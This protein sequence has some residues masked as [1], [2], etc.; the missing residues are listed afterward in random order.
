MMGKSD[1]PKVLRRGVAGLVILLLLLL[2]LGALVGVTAGKE[3]ALPC[4][5]TEQNNTWPCCKWTCGA[6]D[7]QVKRVYL[8]NDTGAPLPTCISGTKVDAYIWMEIYNNA[9][10]E[11]TALILMVDVYVDDSLEDTTCPEGLCVLDSILGKKTLNASIYHFTWTCGAV[12][13]VTE[14]VLSA[15]TGNNC[16]TAD[17]DCNSERTAKCYYSPGFIVEAP[18][19]A[20]FTTAPQ[21]YCT[22]INFY[23]TATGGTPDY[24]YSWDFGDG[25][26]TTGQNTNYHYGAAGTYSD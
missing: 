6:N 3:D 2:L 13:N 20:N 7:I 26:S 19:A 12:V 25:N 18:L 4:G 9:N 1:Y 23:G 14:I 15:E 8:G 5:C 24:D 21:C 11:R 22:D 10:N 17:R 16:S